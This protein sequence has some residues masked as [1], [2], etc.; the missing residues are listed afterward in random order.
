MKGQILVNNKTINVKIKNYVD[1]INANRKFYSI[2]LSALCARV[3]LPFL[4]LIQID[5][6]KS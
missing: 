4:K 1:C 3:L 5:I 6:K 2:A